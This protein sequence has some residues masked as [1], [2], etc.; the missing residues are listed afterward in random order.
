MLCFWWLLASSGLFELSVSPIPFKRSQN[1]LERS[2]ATPI[3]DPAKFHFSVSVQT[4][5]PQFLLSIFHFSAVFGPNRGGRRPPNPAVSVSNALFSP[6][7]SSPR[8]VSAENTYFTQL[9]VIFHFHFFSGWLVEQS[10]C[11]SFYRSASLV[12]QFRY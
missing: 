5:Q 4:T 11:A 2:S 10:S 1:R 12:G 8:S 7:N 9:L 6:R 3:S